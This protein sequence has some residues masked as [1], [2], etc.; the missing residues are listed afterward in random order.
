MAGTLII[1]RL[2]TEKLKA[3]EQGESTHSPSGWTDHEWNPGRLAQN[4]VNRKGSA[5]IRTPSHRN[6]PQYTQRS[7]KRGK[8][9]EAGLRNN[10]I[11]KME[12]GP[13]Y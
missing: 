6:K 4:Q 13:R 8:I 10:V 5:D 9:L 11:I 2:Y 3:A 7:E 1:I 12:Q